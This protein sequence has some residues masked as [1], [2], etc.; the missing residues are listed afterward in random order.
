MKYKIVV[1]SSSNLTSTYINSP[2]IGFEVVP[3]TIRVDEKIYVDDDTLDVDAMLDA[4]NSSQNKA[5]SSC[6]SPYDFA[7]TFEG[8][9]NVF[10]VT[11][12]S[13]LSGCY[14]SARLAAEQTEGK[15][16]YV[17]DSKATAGSM[18][19]IVN[20]LKELIDANL[21]FEEI[22][23]QIDEYINSINLLFVLSKFDNLV[24][25]GRMSRLTAVIATALAIKPLCIGVDGEIK[26]KEKIRTFSGVL[27]R[28]VVN[29]GLLCK[30][31]HNRICY[32]CQTKN[33]ADSLFL[34]KLIS[35]RYD[36]KEVKIVENRG[37]CAFYSLE[38]GIIVSF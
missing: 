9:E 15:N 25:N 28:L 38:K 7:K 30:E 29:I 17:I 24:K 1:D 12:S 4:V 8:A 23:T 37:L 2:E 32:I 33:L 26:I 31:T 19:L 14:N 5:T 20:K 27:R 35:E 11:I 21:S 6:P 10:V 16:I 3:L 13:K 34:Q 22:K 18:I 36:F